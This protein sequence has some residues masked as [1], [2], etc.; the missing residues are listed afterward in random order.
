MFFLISVQKSNLILM[1]LIV[2]KKK[3]TLHN[4]VMLMKS[5]L[6]KDKN[7]CYHYIFLEKC[8]IN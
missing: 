2:Y 6:D 5:V 7:H 8:S 3:L 1:I 4:D